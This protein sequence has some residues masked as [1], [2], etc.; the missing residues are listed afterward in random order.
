MRILYHGI[1]MLIYIYRER[2]LVYIAC[3]MCLLLCPK[4]SEMGPA[5]PEV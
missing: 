3:R 4:V 1:V 2:E 5:P